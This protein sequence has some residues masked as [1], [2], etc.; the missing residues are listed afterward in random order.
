[1]TSRV[2]MQVNNRE[3]GQEVVLDYADIELPTPGL[4]F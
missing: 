2:N 4:L 3:R 1:M